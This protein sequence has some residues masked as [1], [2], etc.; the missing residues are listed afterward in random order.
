MT[1]AGMPAKKTVGGSGGLHGQRCC[2]VWAS[3]KRVWWAAGGPKM[4]FPFVAK[5]NLATTRPRDG[6]RLSKA[7]QPQESMEDK[8]QRVCTTPGCGNFCKR[9]GARPAR[10]AELHARTVAKRYTRSSPSF[11]LERSAVQ[12]VHPCVRRAARSSGTGSAVTPVVGP[13][14]SSNIFDGRTTGPSF[15]WRCLILDHRIL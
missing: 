5:N 15:I 14:V 8:S 7:A 4:G 2:A 3:A 6:R 12:P 1:T 10:V 13:F 9:V 11:R